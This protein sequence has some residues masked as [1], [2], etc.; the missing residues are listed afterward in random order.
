MG[1]ELHLNP[2]P[3]ESRP[4][5]L[6]I[7]SSNVGKRSL[8]SSNSLSLTYPN[9]IYFNSYLLQFIKLIVIMPVG[10]W[11]HTDPIEVLNYYSIPIV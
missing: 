2:I 8:L 6:F 10:S 11:N 9:S 7:G 5:I 3:L 1:E 4:G